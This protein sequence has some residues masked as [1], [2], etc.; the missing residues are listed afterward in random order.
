MNLKSGILLILI[1]VAL[2][3]ALAATSLLSSKGDWFV[4][5]PMPS[6]QTD[7]F[8]DIG[9]VDANGD[10]RLDIY[11]SNHHFRRNSNT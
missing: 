11:T 6:I 9:I 5:H 2:S 1:L 3:G 4:E 8:F 10:D 7:R